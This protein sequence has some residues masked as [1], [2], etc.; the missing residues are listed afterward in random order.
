ME[1]DIELCA[2]KLHFNSLIICVLTIYKAPAGNINYYTHKIDVIL[3]TFYTAAL[4]FIVCVDVNINCLIDSA[5]K[6]QLDP[7]LFSYNLLDII[8][9]ST[10]VQK[11]SVTAIDNIF[12][13]V[14]QIGN[15]TAMPVVHGLSYHNAQLLI[16]GTSDIQI[17]SH[18]L[19]LLEK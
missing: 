6:S 13:A 11:N 17:Q 9:F 19:I 16:I 5:R 15:C 14:S 12:I 2:L 1:Q 8:K 4:D 10:R 18:Q 7:L 3:H